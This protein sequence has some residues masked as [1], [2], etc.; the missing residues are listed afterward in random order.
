MCSFESKWLQD[1]SNDFTLVFHICYIDET[2]VLLSSPN[3]ADKYRKYLSSK[4]PDIKFSI[5]KEEDGCLP[6]LD[7]NIFRENDKFATNIYR[8]KP[9]AGF[10]PTSQALYLKHMK[11]F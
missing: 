4:H 1:C 5:E 9:S 7:I 11:L 10:I 8:K 3:H 6:L 2:F